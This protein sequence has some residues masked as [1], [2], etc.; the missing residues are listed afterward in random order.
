VTPAPHRGEPAG[1]AF[2]AIQSLARHTSA[3]VQEPAS[4]DLALDLPES[5]TPQPTDD[6]KAA[7]IY[8]LANRVPSAS[9][10]RIV[11]AFGVTPTRIVG[12]PLVERLKLNRAVGTG[13]RDTPRDEIAASLV[14]SATG[15]RGVP[16]DGLPFDEQRGTIRT[17]TVAS[18]TTENIWRAFT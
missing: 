11:L 17:S 18:S 4:I 2:L 14:I 10:K 12:Q 6:L 16:I 7:L 3:D 15:Y 13:W 8:G 9:D 1:D 5:T